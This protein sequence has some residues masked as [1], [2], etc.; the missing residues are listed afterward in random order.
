MF[1]Y[2]IFMVL[3]P[4]STFILP[5][6]SSFQKKRQS[7]HCLHFTN[8]K[9]R[10]KGIDCLT[11]SEWLTHNG[12]WNLG[13]V[14]WKEIKHTYLYC[15]DSQSQCQVKLNDLSKLALLN[16]VSPATVGDDMMRAQ[17][18]QSPGSHPLP[19]APHPAKPAGWLPA[20][21]WAVS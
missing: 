17:K 7:W 20:V 9:M 1:S 12:V 14:L 18:V 3:E 10:P 15:S 16:V 21:N 19:C 13:H 5:V 8:R 11:P 6:I 4:L 2:I